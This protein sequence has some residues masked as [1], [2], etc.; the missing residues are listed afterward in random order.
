MCVVT[1]SQNGEWTDI[2]FV[3]DWRALGVEPDEARAWDMDP[4]RAARWMALGMETGEA[5]AWHDAGF[6][7]EDADGWLGA[8]LTHESAE[9]ARMLEDLAERCEAK[10]HPKSWLQAGHPR[11]HVE[12][13]LRAGLRLHEAPADDPTLDIVF[14][15]ALCPS[16]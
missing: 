12:L 11:E 3:E 9:V 16:Q 10:D 7:T 14:L 6:D 2:E 4:L 5:H 15:A 8:G 13:Y 1:V